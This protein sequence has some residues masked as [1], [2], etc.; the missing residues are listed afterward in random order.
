M[1]WLSVLSSVAETLQ[2]VC[3]T[4]R[5]SHLKRNIVNVLIHVI[6]TSVMIWWCG[7]GDDNIHHS[8]FGG[9]SWDA[10]EDLP[11]I[12]LTQTVVAKQCRLNWLQS[13]ALNKQN[14]GNENI[15]V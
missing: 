13:A 2:W 12:H 1:A 3:Q 6:T 14:E 15:C 4:T 11:W 7:K 9:V 5:H 8:V 10:G